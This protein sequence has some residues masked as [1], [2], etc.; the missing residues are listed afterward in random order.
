MV[1]EADS[2]RKLS[3]LFGVLVMVLSVTSGSVGAETLSGGTA[4][5]GN[6]GTSPGVLVNDA[7]IYNGTD[8]T[9]EVAYDVG[10]HDPS[11]LEVILLDGSDSQIDSNASLSGS[12][13]VVEL[14]IPAGENAD[15][16]ADA[17][18]FNTSSGQM[19]KNTFDSA[20][21]TVTDTKYAPWVNQA[22][23]SHDPT[24][25]T[26]LS[27]TYNA[28]G[29]VT[30]A[31]DVAVVLKDST[32]TT[33]AAN[34][35]LD[36]TEGVA[37]VTIPGGTFNADESMTVLLNDTNKGMTLA[38]D[39]FGLTAAS[40][41]TAA[42]SISNV[43]FQN[44][45][46]Y[47]YVTFDSNETLGSNAADV[48]VEVTGPNGTTYAFDRTQF[49]TSGTGPYTYE[50]SVGQQFTDGSGTYTTEVRDAVDAAGNN[51][52]TNGGGSGL[53]AT[54]T[55]S[56]NGG[57]G[58]G[59]GGGSDTA[60]PNV[61]SVDVS[62]NFDG[63]LSVTFLSNESLGSN[64]GD[65]S[66]TV[67]G[68]QTTAV[69]T[70]DR[71][72]FNERSTFSG[73]EYTLSADQS[74]SDGD[75]YYNATVDVAKDAA[76]ND[77]GGTYLNDSFLFID[78]MVN[79]SSVS[80]VS[81]PGDEGKIGLNAFY[82]SG[83]LQIQVKNDS[84]G[85][86][87][88]DAGLTKDTELQMTVEVKSKKPRALI[89]NGRSVNWTRTQ[90]EDGN[91]TITI[92]GTPSETD[93]YFPYPEE[94]TG[95]LRATTHRNVSMTFA[96][97]TLSTF[98]A[99]RRD[100]LSGIVFMTDAQSFAPPK[101]NDSGANPKI[102][103]DVSAPHFNESGQLNY[104][105]AEVYLP[106]SLLDYWGVTGSAIEGQYNGQSRSTTLT[107]VPGGGVQ[108]SVDVHYSSGTA[109]FTV[110][111]TAPAAEAGSDV[112]AEAGS[113]VDFDGT[114][115]TDNK[116]IDTYEWDFDGDG[117]TDATGATPST[118]FLSTGTH[119]VELT[120]TDT[121]GNTATDTL[122][123]TVED[124]TA[125]TA[126][127]GS[128]RTVEAGDAVNFDASG[129]TDVVGVTSYE[130]DFDGDG[131][132][133]ATGA[134]PSKT[135][136]STGSKTATVTVADA[137]GNEATASVTVTVADTT[138]PT[139]SVGSDR[140]IT[141]GDSVTFDATGSM[142]VVGVT[143]YEWDF[144]GDGQTDATGA[145]P[146]RTFD[147]TGTFTVTFTASDAAGNTDTATLSVDVSGD[148]DSGG[149]DGSDGSDGSQTTTEPTTTEPTT[150]EST[151]TESTTTTAEPSTPTETSVPETEDG[152]TTAA[153]TDAS[154][155]DGS[156]TASGGDGATTASGEDGA[157]S[158]REQVDTASESAAGSGG[159]P[160]FGVVVA[161]VA[162]MGAALLARHR[163][164]N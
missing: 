28:T 43:T 14:T 53:T 30:A 159:S 51:G 11:N 54:V 13:G 36:A 129:S 55:A 157:A 107:N 163:R 113:S 111:S 94:W 62:K 116:E 58:G 114:S 136:T 130:W 31:G 1:G 70:F 150:T 47:M 79:S 48:L 137:A 5:A 86:E 99:E 108:A 138:A 112:T 103:F 73:Y 44:A 57:G 24:T 160:G 29:K 12:S 37:E 158:T 20:S 71:S 41:D 66:V 121:A 87:L 52:G 7:T 65:L 15:F 76:G 85:Y 67:D 117:Q 101:Y 72:Q 90:N 98:P 143:S 149:S 19:V 135:W 162:L 84:H 2:K 93:Y 42:P 83:L 63:N 156:T 153:P 61:T 46:G 6:V 45:S 39:Q 141:V 105:F 118:T 152:S 139:A 133:D 81:G 132:T 22:D 134:T 96:S 147:S 60:A 148:G 17:F 106:Q 50:I 119:T 100:S 95:N 34:A 92:T 82:A 97:D 10:G 125:P 91:W 144:D 131:Q 151:T 142:D 38:F 27:V 49:T 126:N 164:T 18:L 128:D 124:T 109:A 78:P 122:T 115:S 32:G 154:D 155:D 16:T 123:V 56:G 9:V 8:S 64:A 80:I 161:F 4:Q 35:S 127:V 89:G 23:T 21:I 26:T 102:E 59:G 110:D 3:A 104:G 74:F 68:P 33:V 88:E 146:T 69:Y 75:G 120:V 140:S 145:T 77:A 25:D 40:S